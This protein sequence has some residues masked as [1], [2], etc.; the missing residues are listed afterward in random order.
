MKVIENTE[1]L[2]S[3]SKLIPARQKNTGTWGVNTT[4][5]VTILYYILLY[6]TIL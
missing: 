4:M 5:V 6:Y 2:L 3:N 1:L